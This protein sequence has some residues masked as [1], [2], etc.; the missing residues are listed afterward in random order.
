MKPIYKRVLLKISGEALAGSERFGINEEMTR[1][2]ASEVKQIHD[3]G[4]EVAIV[5]GG[6]NFWRGRTSKDMD[7]ATADYMGMLATVM[8]SLALQDAFLA[9]G[10]PAKV[11]TAI[12]MREVAEPY[13]RRK[14]L[15]HLEHGSVVIFGAG[16]GNPFFSTDTTAALRAAEID[17]DVILLAKNIDG[18]YDSDPAVNRDAKMFTELTHMEVVEKDL[19]VMDL[20]AATLCKD[21][22]IKIHV[23]AIAEEG[24]VLKAIAGEKIGTIIK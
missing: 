3:L 21:N 22:N 10:V 12:E 24:D 18:V 8:N 11:Q 2:V 1:K 15:S 4:V 16:T 9:L 23:F 6:G 20:T 14:A 17:A 5:V 13:A 19:K 7:R